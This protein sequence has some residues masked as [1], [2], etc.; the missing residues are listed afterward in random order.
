MALV[1]PP[2]RAAARTVRAG[3]PSAAVGQTVVVATIASRPCCTHSSDQA[4]QEARHAAR[5]P[6]RRHQAAQHKHLTTTLAATAAA[7]AA[8]VPACADPIQPAA[9]AVGGKHD[10]RHP[11]PGTRASPAAAGIGLAGGA[12][13]AYERGPILIAASF[14]AAKSSASSRLRRPR[15]QAVRTC[16]GGPLPAARRSAAR[17]AAH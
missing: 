8:A 16:A 12:A 15:P 2:R 14:R 17:E 11:C 7:A 9:A 10:E 13:A 6:P 4:C 5:D 3:D 1:F